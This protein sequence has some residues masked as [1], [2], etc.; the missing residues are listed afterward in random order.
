MFNKIVMSSLVFS[1][2]SCSVHA[3][4]LDDI[5]SAFALPANS[6]TAVQNW[7]T[8]DAMTGVHWKPK[9]ASVDPMTGKPYPDSFDRK[10][11]VELTTTIKKHP[12]ITFTTM[13]SGDKNNITSFVLETKGSLNKT[14]D[15]SPSVDLA[16]MQKLF[17]KPIDV[18]V[19]RPAC[20]SNMNFTYWNLYTLVSPNKKPLFISVANFFGGDANAKPTT[21]FTFQN[22]P[23][24]DDDSGCD[25]AN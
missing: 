12:H 21:T 1:A 14:A 6:T 2:L 22:K 4:S 20:N 16:T 15:G 3:A 11:Q 24:S 19:S 18:K 7:S 5:V 9:S 23:F 8:I 25:A 13:A 17:S 10:G